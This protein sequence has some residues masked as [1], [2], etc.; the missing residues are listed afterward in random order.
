MFPF[1]SEPKPSLEDRLRIALSPFPKRRFDR[2][3]VV[4]ANAPSEISFRKAAAGNTF[5]C[6]I[7]SQFCF[8]RVDVALCSS[9]VPCLPA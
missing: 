8:T 7:C 3:E 5:R 6:E 9:N 2:S 1:A 4:E